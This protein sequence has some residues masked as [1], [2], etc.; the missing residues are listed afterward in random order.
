[1]RALLRPGQSLQLCPHQPLNLSF[2][3]EPKRAQ[4]RRCHFRGA[5]GQLASEALIS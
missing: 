1:L 4:G 2:R 3:A 5:T